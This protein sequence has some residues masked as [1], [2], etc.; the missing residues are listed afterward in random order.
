[1]SRSS[2]KGI[3]LIIPTITWGGAEKVMV[4]L[5]EWWA[6]NKGH[7][8]LITFSRMADEIPISKNVNRVFLE[9]LPCPDNLPVNLEWEEETE[10]IYKLASAI[11]QTQKKYIV[12]F[13]SRMNVRTLIAAPRESK[14]VVSEHSYPPLREMPPSFEELR[15]KWYQQAH[16]VILLT[17]RARVDWADTFLPRQKT[18]VI[19]NP[20]LP[21]ENSNDDVSHILPPNY[22]LA[23]GRLA[24]GKGHDILIKAFSLFLQRH[25]G[26]KLVLIGEGPEYNSIMALVEKLELEDHVLFLKHRNRVDIAMQKALAL[27]LSSFFEGFPNVLVEAM[28][29]GTACIASD[30]KTGPSELIKSNHSGILFPP[31]NI[32]CLHRAM[33][34]IYT[35]QDLRNKLINNARQKIALLTKDKIFPQWS[36]LFF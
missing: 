30:C 11:Q 24:K 25:E 23:V 28:A 16:R 19:Q 10:N 27:I 32:H 3:C 22:F 14:V 20:F 26:V 31:G 29:Y 1:M 35:K 13:L 21:V 34:I 8:D 9:D 36:G 33:E 18:E 17:Q 2:T 4:H 6:E 5:A 15:K 12:S 7:V